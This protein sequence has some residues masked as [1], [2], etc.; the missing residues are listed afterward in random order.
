M[1]IVKA[2]P[3]A[4]LGQRLRYLREVRGWSQEKVG[5]EIGLDESSARARISRYELGVHEP[6]I[7]TARLLATVM[8]VPLAYLYCD[9]EQVASLLLA[10]HHAKPAD[11]K[12]SI[13]KLCQEL[14]C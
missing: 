5:V 13:A 3:S 9:D 1:S 7:A 6:P 11:R 12:I 4:V 8:G 10:L 2:P 14:G